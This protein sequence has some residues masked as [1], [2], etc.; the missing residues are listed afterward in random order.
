MKLK[1]HDIVTLAVDLPEDGLR[2]GETGTIVHVHASG[3]AF[4]VEF[5]DR[6]RPCSLRS[7]LHRSSSGVRSM[8]GAC[9]RALGS[10]KA[11]AAPSL[12]VSLSNRAPC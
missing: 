7:Y 12:V 8:V 11:V 6:E 9:P 10:R 2:A 4:V 1:E 5:A 3:K